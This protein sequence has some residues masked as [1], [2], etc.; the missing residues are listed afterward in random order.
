MA[1]TRVGA[2]YAEPKDGGIIGIAGEE[3]LAEAFDEYSGEVEDAF[4]EDTD[5]DVEDD[6]AFLG[7]E[8]DVLE[9]DDVLELCN[10]DRRNPFRN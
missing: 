2:T 4:D 1:R 5:F 6:I 8:Y 9:F 7:E 10:V 3:M